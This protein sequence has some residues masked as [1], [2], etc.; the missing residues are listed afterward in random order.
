MVPFGV[1]IEV[2]LAD[3]PAFPEITNPP[4]ANTSISWIESIEYACFGVAVNEPPTDT[5]DGEGDPSPP[6]S[7]NISI[8]DGVTARPGIHEL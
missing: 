6:S 4:L 8:E 5:V 7:A 3:R 1:H 2:D